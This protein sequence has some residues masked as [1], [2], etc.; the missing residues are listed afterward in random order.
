MKRKKRIMPSQVIN[1]NVS[2]KQAT[3]ENTGWDKKTYDKKYDVMR[4]RVKNYNLMYGT[5]YS[6]AQMLFY[7]STGKIYSTTQ[8]IISTST[9]REKD[10]KYKIAS[11]QQTYK[12]DK[13]EKDFSGLLAQADDLR[14]K[15]EQL[16]ND[17]ANYDELYY[18]L[19]NFADKLRRTKEKDEHASYKTIQYEFFTII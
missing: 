5:N 15:Y 17:G 8:E 14:Q 9:H 18:L 1:D 13:L 11:A 10:F 7:E 2:W 3:L 12:I 6:P 19:A 4:K 16:K